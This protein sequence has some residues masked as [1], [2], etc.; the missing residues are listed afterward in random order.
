M[1][2]CSIPFMNVLQLQAMSEE[3]TY[4]KDKMEEDTAEEEDSE[5]SANVKGETSDND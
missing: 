2:P 4:S 5:R 1:F 3:S